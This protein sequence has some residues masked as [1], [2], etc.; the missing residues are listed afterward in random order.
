MMWLRG[1]GV[2]YCTYI[3]G[4]SAILNEAKSVYVS[5]SRREEV[6]VGYFTVCTGERCQA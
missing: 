6:N 3:D 1:F 5:S 4:F 2:E